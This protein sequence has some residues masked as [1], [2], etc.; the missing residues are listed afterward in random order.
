MEV[1]ATLP[2]GVKVR[3]LYGK[4]GVLFADTDA[5]LFRLVDDHMVRDDP[6]EITPKTPLTAPPH[7][8]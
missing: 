7:L 6:D 5:G 3:A 8:S 2:E 4:D 1:F